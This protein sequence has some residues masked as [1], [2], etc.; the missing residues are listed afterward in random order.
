MPGMTVGFCCIIRQFSDQRSI[1]AFSSSLYRRI[2]TR[3]VCGAPQGAVGA[4]AMTRTARLITFDDVCSCL[5]A[6]H[7]WYSLVKD[8]DVRTCAAV[9]PLP[10]PE[11]VVMMAS[12]APVMPSA[13]AFA[14]LAAAFGPIPAMLY[15]LVASRL[16][17]PLP[18]WGAL[19]LLARLCGGC[20]GG[21]CWDGGRSSR[22]VGTRALRFRIL[23]ECRRAEQQSSRCNTKQNLIHL[24]FRR[25]IGS[26]IE[27]SCGYFGSKDSSEQASADPAGP[28]GYAAS[29]QCDRRVSGIVETADQYGSAECVGTFA[30]AGRAFSSR[31]GEGPQ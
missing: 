13:G 30:Y 12:P 28:A 5:V 4:C 21:G 23:G 20:W 31:R 14:T 17:A 1:A 16:F 10:T 26:E 9:G 29:L 15:I 27:R 11:P 18:A 25:L 3:G 22:S 19:V 8:D 6:A 24:W 2:R 7:R